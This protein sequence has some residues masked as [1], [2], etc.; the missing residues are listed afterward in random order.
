MRR[1]IKKFPANSLLTGKISAER[2]ALP[3]ASRT[4]QSDKVTD[5]RLRAPCAC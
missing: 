2:G 5:F 1:K 3:T 4:N